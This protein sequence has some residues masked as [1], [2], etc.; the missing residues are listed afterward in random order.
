MAAATA[1]WPLVRGIAGRD[2]L[3]SLGQPVEWHD[4]PMEHSV[5]HGRGAGAQRVAAEGAGLR[6]S[7]RAR[8]AT[9]ATPG[10]APGRVHRRRFSA[11]VGPIPC[12]GRP[13]AHEELQRIAADPLPFLLHLDDPEGLG[14]RHAARRQ[15]ASAPASL[16]ALDV[17]EHD[18]VE[19]FVGSIGLRWAA[20]GAP[21]PAHVLGHVG[22]AVV[23]WKRRRGFR[24]PRPG[25]DA[26]AG[27]RAGA[28]L[29]DLTTDPDNLAS[30]RVI[31]ANG[32][33]FVETFD[34]GR[35]LRPRAGPSF[36]HRAG[37][38]SEPRTG[39]EFQSASHAKRPCRNH[40][41]SP[42]AAGRRPRQIHTSEPSSAWAMK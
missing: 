23:P 15:P 37:A 14:P 4:Y 7:S 36:R 33:I 6:G 10:A 5:V 18:A 29:P 13:A 1:S 11:V 26:A 12:R 3:Q 25:A 2:L 21:L 17:D 19:P 38:V 9:R 27:A 32:G 20:G 31:A 34:K 42:A 22:Y 28:A 24:H 39:P 16:A 35:G 40:P 41:A 30:Q 8:P